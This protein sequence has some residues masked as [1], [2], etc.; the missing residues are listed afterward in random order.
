MQY[1]SF[2]HA[3]AGCWSQVVTTILLADY[4]EDD[5][6]I[7]GHCLVGIEVAWRK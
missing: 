6:G 1:L 7:F 4:D 5:C 3:S 2:E